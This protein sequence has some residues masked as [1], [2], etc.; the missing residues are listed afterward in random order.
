MQT[1]T[2]SVFPDADIVSETFTVS[3][4]LPGAAT[5]SVSA[6]V[7][8][9]TPVRVFGSPD[10]PFRWSWFSPGL[11]RARRF[12]ID[13]PATTLGRLQLRADST[14]K[15]ARMAVYR[16]NWSTDSPGNLIAASAT[17]PFDLVLSPAQS[18]ATIEVALQ[19]GTY[20]LAFIIDG[21][22]LIGGGGSFPMER[23]CFQS[24]A[25]GAAFPQTFPISACTSM[26]GP[27]SLSAL[28]S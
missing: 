24:M 2:V 28:G 8:D 4:T 27:I 23:G 14:G 18:G 26:E 6:T 5:A 25:F 22:A 1:I 13:S 19:P 16:Q 10:V 9:S 12:T 3:A 17:G 20:W 15:R 21:Q 11:L 7:V